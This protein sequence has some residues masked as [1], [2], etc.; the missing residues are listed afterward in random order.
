MWAPAMHLRQPIRNRG[1]RCIYQ[2]GVSC[3]SKSLQPNERELF[4]AVVY[5]FGELELSLQLYLLSFSPHIFCL[6]F[7]AAAIEHKPPRCTRTT[8]YLFGESA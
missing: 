1:P 7:V 6:I 4:V 2:R 3:A 5:Q 8:L